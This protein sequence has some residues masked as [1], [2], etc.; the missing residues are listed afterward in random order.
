MFERYTEKAR[1]VIFFARYEASQFGSRF[2][3][4]H[5]LLL[6]IFRED[7]VLAPMISLADE[8]LAAI[9]KR[10]EAEFPPGATVSA[11][12]DMPLSDEARQ[13][14]AYAAEESERLSQPS[15]APLHILIGVL[16]VESSAASRVL[17][18]R[19]AHPA[20]LRQEALKLSPPVAKSAR[21]AAPAP[22]LELVDI[23]L[24]ALPEDRR[25]AAA[26][27][28]QLLS[29]DSVSIAIASPHGGYTAS[30]HEAGAG[31]N[32][33][34]QYP[35]RIR[36]AVFFA[37]YEA[38]NVGAPAVDTEHLLLGVLREDATLLPAL[39]GSP[40]AIESVRAAISERAPASKS[41]ALAL[42]LPLTQQARRALAFAKAEAEA[43]GHSQLVPGHV[44]LG[45]LHEG[46][47]FAAELLARHGVTLDSARTKIVW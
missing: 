28:I 19:G 22:Q 25:Q 39:L 30:F 40:G 9:R 43:L 42:D 21:V 46:G 16:R 23:L 6:A 12:V 11:A 8:D 18:E 13:A 14:L 2:I 3:E 37:R 33:L 35:E 31:P 26:R 4:P 32:S 15:V 34:D 20:A 7:R 47:C 44:V 17:R 29:Q 36:R 10:F 41:T 38:A 5:H 24:D 27:V 1:R 45:L